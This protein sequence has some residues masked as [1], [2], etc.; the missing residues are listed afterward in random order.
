MQEGHSDL[1]DDQRVVLY[2]TYAYF[3]QQNGVWKVPIT[4]FVYQMGRESMRQR[5]FL[6][7]LQQIL[8]TDEDLLKT[9]DVFED[10]IRGFLHVP[11]RGKSLVF[12]LGDSGLTATGRS[13][14]SG[15][16]RCSANLSEHDV[17]S[18]LADSPTGQPEQP[19]NYQVLLPPSDERQFASALEFIPPRG[20][21][22][23]SDIDDT[24]K[25]TQVA[26]RKQ[27]LHNTFLNPFVTVPGMAQLY[28]S[29]KKSG[30]AF[31][32]V[33]S[34]PWQLYEPLDELL[35]QSDFPTGSFHLRSYRFGDPTV[36][37]LFLSRKR[38]KYKVIKSIFLRF[39]DRRMVLIG[40]SGEKDPEIYGKVARKFPRQ[41]ERILI[42]RVEGRPWTRKRVR[43]AFRSIP[44]E[45][46][47]TFRVPTQIR[48]L[49]FS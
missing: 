48:E 18:T 15:H 42:R 9:N 1:S 36:V 46:W 19:I 5:M 49:D 16:I 14:R 12:R 17:T 6:R 23:I 2:R 26:H 43:T 31:H 10:R 3:D 7:V 25:I 11:Q 39:P 24:I 40:D 20:I 32:Y 44:R 45:L 22:V 4:G 47:Q 13:K 37:R 33:S 27:L 35:T 21:S 28:Q 29:W 38:N 41:I 34:S 30:A 8:N